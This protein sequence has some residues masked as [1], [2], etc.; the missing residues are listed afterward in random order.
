MKEKFDNFWV[1]L[2]LGLVVPFIAFFGVYKWV[3]RTNSILEFIEK[4]SSWGVQTTVFLW[5]ILP[6]AFVFALFYFLHW[7]NV[8]KGVVFP[9]MI[10]TIVLLILDM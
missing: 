10:Y 8:A 4:L 7:D 6:I 5:C 9:T 2:V 3:N 1:G